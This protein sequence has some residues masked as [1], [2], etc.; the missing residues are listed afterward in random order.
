MRKTF[1]KKLSELAEINKNIILLTGDLGYGV[2]D[3]FEKKYPDQYI[4]CGVAEQNMIGVAA[5][6]AYE[7]KKVFIYS[8]ANF[9]TF[10][11]L[12]QIRNDIC[13]HELPV[14]IVSIGAGFSYGNLG[15]SHYAIEDLTIMR[16]L[17]GL[18]ILSPIDPISVS[19]SLELI[20]KDESPTYLR[21]GKDGEQNLN[22]DQKSEI[23]DLRIICPGENN[24][25]LSTGSIS[26][27]VKIAIENINNKMNKKVS[28]ATITQL[29]PL[30][31]DLEF[32]SKFKK[33]IT[34][35]EHSL[36]G[37][38]GS[39][40][41]DFIIKNALNIQVLNLGIEDKLHKYIGS[42]EYMKKI[43]KLDHESILKNILNF[44]EN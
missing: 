5:G 20:M 39:I 12:E 31:L 38:F 26:L 18:R 9:A 2:F 7:G 22:L 37:G 8:I 21:L 25:V 34:V 42:T 30:K 27:D 35:E 13:Y 11:C 29:K 36:Q 6:M 19:D 16:S 28:F 40:L 3:E 1:I 23:E 4:N 41:N 43:N 10:R 32:L 14:T 44:I 24:L 15:Y 33:I 17:P